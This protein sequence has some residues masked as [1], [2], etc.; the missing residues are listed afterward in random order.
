MTAGINDTKQ[1]VI[2]PNLKNIIDPETRWAYSNIF[3]KLTDVVNKA[4]NKPFETY[5]NE[6]LKSKIGMEGFW[7]FGT[8]F[9]IYH[10]NTKSMARFGLLALNKGK[11]NN[12]QIIN[13][14]YFNESVSTSQSINPS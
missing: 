4:S 13:E 5:F 6:K 11:W 2:K 9:T 7:N 12:E 3:Q 10:S 8:I 1:Y 14:S